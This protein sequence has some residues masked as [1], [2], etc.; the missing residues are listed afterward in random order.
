MTYIAALSKK[1]RMLLKKLGERRA[2]NKAMLAGV[3]Q[4]N[5]NLFGG[6]NQMLRTAEVQCLQHEAQ[7]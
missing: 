5:L 1:A 2:Y 7:V 3:E 4:R 6:I